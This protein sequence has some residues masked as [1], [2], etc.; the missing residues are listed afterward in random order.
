[1]KKVA[2]DRELEEKLSAEGTKIRKKY[3]V[4]KIAEKMLRAAQK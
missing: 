2:E 3:P 1:M 4:E